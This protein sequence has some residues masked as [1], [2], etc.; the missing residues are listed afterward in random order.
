MTKKSN[1]E[2]G[3]SLINTGILKN[4]RK[5]GKTQLQYSVHIAITEEMKDFLVLQEKNGKDK[6]EFMRELLS[7]EIKLAKNKV[8][9]VE[10]LFGIASID[11]PHRIITDLS[12]ENDDLLPE[13]EREKGL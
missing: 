11:F 12:H 10:R 5:K 6:G 3:F 4:K 2:T 1:N 7:T 9:D 13:Y 8:E